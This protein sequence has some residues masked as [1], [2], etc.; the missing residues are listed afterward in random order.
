MV[1]NLIGLGIG[2]EKD[3]TMNGF[4]AIQTS[5]EIYLEHYTSIIKDANIETLKNF[6]KKDIK[7]ASRD[8]VEKEIENIIQEAKTKNISFLI[9]GDVF[10]A[11]THMDLMLRAKELGTKVNIFNNASILNAIGNIG[12]ELYKFGKTTSMVFFEENWKP[13]N[14][15]DIL[16]QNK[17]IQAHTLILLDIKIAEPSLE[18]LKK[19][20][21]K[22]SKPRFM[23]VNQALQ[24]LIEL[25]ETYKENL[26]SKETLAIGVARLNSKSEF[27]KTGT[28]KELLSTDF[29]DPIH[30]LIIPDKM[31]FI[32]EDAINRFK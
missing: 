8:L 11:T 19:G 30:C 14:V 7:L 20:L 32:E 6:Y 24:Q 17:S 23:T 16:K 28:I 2:N 21:T 27:I 26:I 10:S 5:D 18:D 31:H 12:L 15:Y 3:I 4:D 25:E 1:L 9:V 22:A 29:G 13:K